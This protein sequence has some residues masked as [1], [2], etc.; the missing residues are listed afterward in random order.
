MVRDKSGPSKARGKRT[1]R[2]PPA[3]PRP[4]ARA[5]GPPG[6]LGEAML[7]DFLADW[8][9][10]GATA[11]GAM[12]GEKP[13]DYVRVA[14]A[15]VP[16]AAPRK[17]DPLEDMTDAELDRAIQETAA[18]IGLDIGEAAVDAAPGREGAAGGEGTAA[19]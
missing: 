9:E 18:R 15:L 8:L 10:N 2:A 12:R 1:K 11:I 19:D 17:P 7:A 16:K 6:D 14:A 3:R 5:V 13:S 4:A